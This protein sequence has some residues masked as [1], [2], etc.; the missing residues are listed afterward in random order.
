[1]RFDL[2]Q[3]AG[4]DWDVGNLTKSL[5]KHGV[6]TSEAEQIFQNR[7]LLISDDEPHSAAEQRFQALGRTN[8]G[9]RLFAVFTLR[10]D[11]TL[12]RMISVRPMN[13]RERARYDQE[14]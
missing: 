5:V 4:F 8:A 1:M 9:R 11:G 3:V 7:P 6:T 10:A 14:A 2:E 12:L 13:I